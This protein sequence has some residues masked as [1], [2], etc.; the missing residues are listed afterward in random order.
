NY[1]IGNCQSG[2][3]SKLVKDISII[4]VNFFET[5]APSGM[6][7][8]PDGYFIIDSKAI[9]NG[10]TVCNT[11]ISKNWSYI[12]GVCGSGLYNHILTCAKF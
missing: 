6:R 2:T 5:Q 1:R 12:G 4:Q 10:G 8:C 9:E 7:F 11:T 3:W